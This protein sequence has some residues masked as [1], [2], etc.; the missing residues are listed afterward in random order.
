[1]NNLSKYNKVPDWD[2]LAAIIDNNSIF[3]H[4]LDEI[5]NPNKR[6]VIAEFTD[7]IYYWC[8]MAYT[9]GTPPIGS[10]QED[11]DDNYSNGEGTK[12][13]L[14]NSWKFPVTAGSEYIFNTLK[15][16][17]A[18]DLDCETFL[19]KG[20]IKTDSN[21]NHNDYIIVKVV[22]K[23]GLYYPAG[24][25]L[26]TFVKMEYLQSGQQVI[27]INP[28]ASDSMG[29]KKR[30]PSGVYIYVTYKSTGSSNVNV[31]VSAEYRY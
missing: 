19:F 15:L 5:F 30:L 27:D 17:D 3:Y 10:D 20:F 9:S 28:P 12:D 1:M 23:D 7:N 8:E 22:D 13:F 24:T 21:A 31:I 14:R 26:R 16:Q 29:P 2:T 18:D 11:Y 4:S 25:V 6:V